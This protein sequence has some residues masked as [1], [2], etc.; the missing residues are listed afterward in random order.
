MKA[1]CVPVDPDDFYT[2]TC[3]FSLDTFHSFYNFLYEAFGYTTTLKNY[4]IF[5]LF[6]V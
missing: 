5:F 3:L 1:S 2:Q 4:G 6:F